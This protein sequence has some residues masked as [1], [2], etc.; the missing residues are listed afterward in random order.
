ML[1]KLKGTLRQAVRESSSLGPDVKFDDDTQILA[2]GIIDSL[3]IFSV[4]SEIEKDLG[5]SL[6]PDEIAA[7]N[8]QSVNIMMEMVTRLVDSGVIKMDAAE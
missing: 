8:F 7:E 6:P 5:V 1:D 4:M 2:E 3:G